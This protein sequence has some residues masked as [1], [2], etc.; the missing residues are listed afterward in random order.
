M[1]WN[2]HRP[3]RTRPPYV[4][5]AMIGHVR[6]STMPTPVG[7][8]RPSQSARA[9][10]VGGRNLLSVARTLPHATA[11]SSRPCLATSIASHAAMHRNVAEE[12]I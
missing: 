11:V 2:W 8:G 7:V 3:T 4:G 10:R 1:I 6:P 9:G 5:L 12:S